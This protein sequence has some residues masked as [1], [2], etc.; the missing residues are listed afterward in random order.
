MTLPFPTHTELEWVFG[1][2]KAAIEPDLKS[3]VPYCND[4][5]GPDRSVQAKDKNEHLQNLKFARA[6]DVWGRPYP[7]FKTTRDVKADETLWTDYV[8][9]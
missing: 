1:S 8:R 7:F 9:L 5:T 3:A 6:D 4:Y 2:V